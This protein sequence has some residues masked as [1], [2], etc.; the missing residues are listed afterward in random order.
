M[1]KQDLV[2]ILSI[3]QTQDSIRVDGNQKVSAITNSEQSHWKAKPGRK[4][5]KS[6][7]RDD[8]EQANPIKLSQPHTRETGMDGWREEGIKEPLQ[9]RRELGVDRQTDR[10]TDGR[11]VRMAGRWDGGKDGQ[12]GREEWRDGQRYTDGGMEGLSCYAWHGNFL[13]V[14]EVF[15]PGILGKSIISRC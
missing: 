2:R 9:G 4:I 13:L 15:S 7:C 8:M 14:R 12:G 5:K 3:S 11:T 6:R 1:L 10:W